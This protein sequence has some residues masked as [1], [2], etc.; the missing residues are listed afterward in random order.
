M[1][2]SVK[3]RAG[4]TPA[5][6]VDPERTV[7]ITEGKGAHGEFLRDASGADRAVLK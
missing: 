7:V 3:W 6:E 4:P 1:E 2:Q 5:V